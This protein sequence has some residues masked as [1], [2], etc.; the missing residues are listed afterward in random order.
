MKKLLSFL[1][2]L[3]AAA[4]SAFAQTPLLMPIP[5]QQF[6]TP[7]GGVCS[8]CFV[9]TYQ[10]GTY[11][12][13]TTYTDYTGLYANTNPIVLNSAGFPETAQGAQVGVWLSPTLTYRIVLENAA[14]VVLYTVDGVT[15]QLP[16]ATS[17]P[18]AILTG[19]C[20]QISV[21]LPGFQIELCFPAPSTSIELYFPNTAGDTLVARN[22]TDTLTQKTLTSPVINSPTITAPCTFQIANSS[23]TG[24]ALDTLTVLTGAPS[25][26]VIAPT[27]A[28]SGIQGIAISGYGT[29][30]NVCIQQV[31]NAPCVFDGATTANDYVSISTTV[32]GN[33]HDA[34]ISPAGGTQTV[35]RVLST[36]ASSGTYSID[37]FPPEIRSGG[38]TVYSSGIAIT[39]PATGG[40]FTVINSTSFAAGA[41]NAIGKAIRLTAQVT[42]QPG[43]TTN[44]T[45]NLSFGSTSSLNGTNIN[46]QVETASSTNNNGTIMLVCVVATTGTSGTLSCSGFN[47]GSEGPNTPTAVVTANLTAALYVGT[48][49]TLTTSNA[50]NQCTEN[51]L[52]VEQLN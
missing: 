30:G 26:A 34:G 2:L 37:L 6:F 38:G 5:E 12:Q 45:S 25:Q 31:G 19:T 42:T 20:P 23:S 50:G 47:N 33:C 8:G 21:G 11:T 51:L 48:A 40:T 9:Y 44:Q 43:T 27:T 17:N 16:G 35:G 15:A 18:L 7:T 1:I 14:H 39:V 29:T 52:T 36:N 22:T 41:L 32:P 49:C 10:S 13:Q 46:I 3:V 4:S 28:T 24:T